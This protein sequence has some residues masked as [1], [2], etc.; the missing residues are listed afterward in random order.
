[1]DVF[2]KDNLFKAVQTGF[3]LLFITLVFCSKNLNLNITSISRTW[4]RVFFFLLYF[5]KMSILTELSS[6]LSPL[7]KPQW[8]AQ[9]EDQSLCSN[10]KMLL[11]LPVH[12]LGPCWQITSCG[13]RLKHFGLG[14][15]LNTG[16][17]EKCLTWSRSLT[18][19]YAELY[20]RPHLSRFS[21][22]KAHRGGVAQ[23]CV[24]T[25]VSARLWGGIITY[26]PLF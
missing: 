8:I 25:W 20:P 11:P 3:Q 19:A 26:I 24:N 12:A 17:S 16:T 13:R 23:T 9:K 1:M 21:E 22:I 2:P 10:N 7:R 18:R 14:K 15:Y 5:C 4:E 6:L